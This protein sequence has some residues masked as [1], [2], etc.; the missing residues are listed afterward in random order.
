MVLE[1]DITLCQNFKAR[2]DKLK[3]RFIQHEVVFLGYSMYSHHRKTYQHQY[4]STVNTKKTMILPLCRQ[5]WKGGTFCYAINKIGAQRMLDSIE[6]FGIK[7]PIDDQ[8]TSVLGAELYE[9]QP[10]LAVTAWD[11]DPNVKLDTD[12]QHSY[13]ADPWLN[14]YYTQIP[15]HTNSRLVCWD[16]NIPEKTCPFQLATYYLKQQHY[17]QAITYLHQQIQLDNDPEKTY[18]SKYALGLSTYQLNRNIEEVHH[19]FM[20]AY[21]Y[22]PF[23]LEAI[24]FLVHY[25]RNHDPEL[26]YTIGKDAYPR[27]FRYPE[28]DTL[29]VDLKVYQHIFADNLA[30]CAYYAGDHQMA[31]SLYDRL[32][33]L[34][35]DGHIT[36]D[37]SRLIENKQYSAD[38]LEQTQDPENTDATDSKT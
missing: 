6:L 10:Q 17:T 11:E 35:K 14:E 22:R 29:R 5:R 9:S 12:I 27:C 37:V 30:V 2:V 33:K 1:D 36:I 26:G 16:T 31:I 8:I 18:W 20:E 21:Q 13:Q 4:S 23:R 7:K 38:Q 19:L 15:R 34:S 3:Q 25:Y 28:S 24:S 32:I